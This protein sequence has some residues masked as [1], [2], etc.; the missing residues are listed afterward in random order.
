[1]TVAQNIGGHMK[2][3]K[4]ETCLSWEVGGYMNM[5]V[6][7]WSLVEMNAWSAL[8][9]VFAFTLHSCASIILDGHYCSNFVI[10]SAG[11][12]PDSKDTSF[13]ASDA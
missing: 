9:T 4:T 2:K 13:N 3:Q 6:V 7:T 11:R 5:T 8:G 12:L 10:L 1:M